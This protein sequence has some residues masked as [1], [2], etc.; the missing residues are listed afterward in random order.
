VK[1]PDSESSQDSGAVVVLAAALT[2]GSLSVSGVT[3]VLV[4]EE[5]K[6]ITLKV[7]PLNLDNNQLTNS[8]PPSDITPAT[9]PIPI[10]E[11]PDTP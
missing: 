8:N 4:H 11:T 6:H 7:D 9:L 3:T 2:L 10:A 5:F 1:K